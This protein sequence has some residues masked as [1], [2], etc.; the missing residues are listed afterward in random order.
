M[1]FNSTNPVAVGDDVLKSQ[2]DHV[3]D[4]VLFLRNSVLSLAAGDAN[5]DIGG[6]GGGAPVDTLRFTTAGSKL[7]RMEDSASTLTMLGGVASTSGRVEYH[8]QTAS[9]G[10]AVTDSLSFIARDNAADRMAFYDQDGT[11]LFGYFELGGLTVP[12]SVTLT[13]ADSKIKRSG[14]GDSLILMGGTSVGGTG[15]ADSFIQL[16][17]HDDTNSVSVDFMS[18]KSATAAGGYRWRQADHTGT[19]QDET[20][21]LLSSAGLLTVLNDADSDL[22]VRLDPGN[23]QIIGTSVT[24]ATILNIEWAGG[25]TSLNTTDATFDIVTDSGG[26]PDTWRFSLNQFAMPDKGAA[27]TSGDG[28]LFYYAAGGTNGTGGL[29]VELNGVAQLIASGPA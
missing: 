9:T 16:A 29:Y 4:N 23:Q 3:F 2:Y 14:Q 18:A 12:T 7:I 17:G 19:P 10:R 8:G 11:T 22:K 21:M 28:S 1:A 13:G 25:V 20:L 15:T 27:T 5:T 26:T 24:G 6:T